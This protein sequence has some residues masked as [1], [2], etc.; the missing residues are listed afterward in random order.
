MK[1][2][3]IALLVCMSAASSTSTRL[4]LASQTE[5]VVVSVDSTNLGFTPSTVAID[6]GY[7]SLHRGGKLPPA[8]EVDE[9]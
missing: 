3:V 2:L 6:E 8:V 9:I 1:R 7:S 4:T 5:T